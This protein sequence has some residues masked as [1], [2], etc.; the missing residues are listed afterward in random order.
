MSVDAENET[1]FAVT[2]GAGAIGRHLL[3]HLGP[4][5]GTR[6]RALIHRHPLASDL[7]NGR[8]SVHRGNLL[9]RRSLDGWLGPDHTVIHL[10]WSS[11]MSR[12]DARTATDNLADA[13]AAAGIR[14]L[15]HVSTAV[16]AG[17][18]GAH[19]VDE[20]TPCRPFT[21]YERAK[22]DAEHRLEAAARNRFALTILRP[23]AV[24][25]P[26]LKTL[27]SLADALLRGSPLVNYARA[28]LFGRRLLHLL[29][30]EML[31][32]ALTF[33]ASRPLP[34]NDLAP[35]R[36]I[37]SC[38]SEPG[39]DF[40]SVERRLCRHLGVPA[41]RVPLAPVPAAVLRQV[42][43]AAGRSDRDPGRVYDGTRL[44]RAGFRPPV[45]LVD[46]VD[47]FAIWYRQLAASASLHAG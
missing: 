26:G 14:R 37:V 13:C 2:G 22:L 4:L 6:V 30:V 10:A 27:V 21:P 40:E 5:E 3:A 34:A 20:A 42:L 46:A 24:F 38:D 7:P 15:L 11:A 18:T 43:G 32:A 17:R 45:T 29:P 44:M 36:F 1:T 16:V 8:L 41:R 23:T 12:D 35:A 33:V 9:D 28:S 31:V 47:R 25:G 39:G 19:I